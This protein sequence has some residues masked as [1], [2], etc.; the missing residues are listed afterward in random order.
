[1]I[2]IVIPVYNAEKYIKDC[3]QSILRQTH[4]SFEVIVVDDGS[5]DK[6]KDICY[7]YAEEYDCVKVF[8]QNNRGAFCARKKG[9]LHSKGEYVWFVDSDDFV[10]VDAIKKIESVLNNCSPDIIQF[11]YQQVSVSGRCMN[12]YILPGR[13]GY[14][15]RFQIEKEILPTLFYEHSFIYFSVNPGLWNKIIRRDHLMKYFNELNNEV[16]MGE[17]GLVTYQCYLNADSIYMINDEILYFYRMNESSVT[18]T[19]NYRDFIGQNII[20]FAE[21]ETILFSFSKKDIVE[22]SYS[23][24]VF[25]LM[26]E[27]MKALFYYTK[28]NNSRDEK[29]RNEWKRFKCSMELPYIKKY[30]DKAKFNKITL[31]RKILNFLFVNKKFKMIY[32][33]WFW[34]K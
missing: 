6:S 5:T 31:K 15:N 9:L 4:K 29:I 16:F 11:S 28:Y 17:D 10:C 14:Y 24:Y 27:A 30:I 19:A 7:K 3:I 23:A 1:M 20:L 33:I 25:F 12:N 32:C 2:S 18:K 8:S 34:K 26:W 13:N 21:W 22:Q